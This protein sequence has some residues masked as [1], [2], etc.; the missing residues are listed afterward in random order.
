MSSRVLLALAATL[1]AGLASAQTFT[2][3][4]SGGRETPTAGD[5]DGRGFAVAILD[6]TSLNYYVMVESITTPTAADIGVG[7]P[8]QSGAVAVTLT[9]TFT[10]AAPGAFIAVGSVTI[11]SATA[12]GV[13]AN[14]GGYYFNVHN[15]D[16]PGGALRGQLIGDG[17]TSST[18]A[19]SLLG[20]R[21]VPSAGSPSGR[22]YAAVTFDTSTIYYFLWVKN[23]D[24]LTGAGIH[25]GDAGQA[26]SVVVNLSPTFAG[27]LAAGWANVAAATVSG[28]LA[29]PAGF[30]VEVQSAGFASGAVRGQLGAP[31]TTIYFPVVSKVSGQ[32]GSKFRTNVRIANQSDEV[33]PVWAEFYP[34]NTAGLA[35]PSATVLLNVAAGAQGVYDEFVGSV[36]NTTGNGAARLV[37]GAPIGAAAHIYNDQRDNPAIG[38]TYGQFAPGRG[39]DDALSQGALLLLSN[40][41]VTDATGFR[42]NLGYYNQLSHTATLSLVARNVDGTVLGTI[43]LAMPGGA[44][45]IDSVFNIISSVPSNQRTIDNFF[46]TYSSSDPIFLYASLVDNK[47]ND[48][49]NIIPVPFV[50]P[51]TVV[52]N[53][54]PDG[55][56]TSPATDVTIRAGQSVSFAGSAS[57]PDGDAVTVVWNFGD[58]ATSTALVAGAHVYASAGVYTV[59]LTATDNKGLADPSPATRSITVNANQ[60]PNGTITAPAGNVTVGVGQ[61]VS[62]AS[63]TSDPDG[64]A[65]TVL[66]N[67]GDGVTSTGA[68][69]SHTYLTAGTYTVTLIATDALGLADPTPD[70]RTIT[71]T[72]VTLSAVQSQIFTPI[73]ARCHPPNQ[74]M[75][76]RVGN[77]WASIVNVNS[78]EQPTLKRVKPGDPDNSYLYRKVN[79]GPSITGSQMPLGGPTLSQAQIQLL[80]DWIL[81]GAPNN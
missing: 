80:H 9:T 21:E 29:D 7:R 81:A 30:Y 45:K 38:G 63:S 1:V 25:Q 24:S 40:R 76:L 55:T 42:S 70:T 31:E 58:A 57:D 27:G 66:W 36:F 2:A 54:P 43:T 52:A 10:S 17:G 26:G 71:V 74:G 16:F 56:I 73:C 53:Q 47:T 8:G 33:A 15:S 41:P 5:P 79:G 49:L 48:G 28:F 4:L 50:E 3:T 19:T 64:D 11:D 22:G 61:S 18:L 59:T 69:P 37:S 75:D 46:V 77:S 78:A 68:A 23:V 35:A 12:Q 44:N 32:G 60:A 6:G 72:S 67:F 20:S 14:P 62:F 34:S 51:V 65:V 39:P 13:A